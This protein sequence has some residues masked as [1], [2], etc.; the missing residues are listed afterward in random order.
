MADSASPASDVTNTGNSVSTRMGNSTD[1]SWAG[2]AIS[3][4]TNKMTT[5]RGEIQVTTNGSTSTTQDDSRPISLPAAGR[6]TPAVSFSVNPNAGQV[7]Q[8]PISAES[9]MLADQEPDNTLDA[10]ATMEDEDDSFFDASPTRKLSPNPQPM[11]KDAG[12]VEPDFAGWLAAQSKAK[13]EKPL[14][15]GLNKTSKKGLALADSRRSTSTM[16]S[17]VVAQKPLNITSKPD[18]PIKKIDIKPRET[19][20][21]EDGWGDDW[22]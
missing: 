19:G 16:S 15:K 11:I 10:W 13:S 1:T 8:K 4:F 22:D 21:T 14:P 20:L 3:S 18:V 7:E 9:F 12:E 2:W 5:A 6:T 17:R